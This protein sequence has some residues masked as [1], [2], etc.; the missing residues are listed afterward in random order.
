MGLKWRLRYAI[1]CIFFLNHHTV[2]CGLLAYFF[3]YNPDCGLSILQYSN[4]N[5][6]GIL[7]STTLD[8]Q[9]ICANWVDEDMSDSI[10]EKMYNHVHAVLGEYYEADLRVLF[11]A[12]RKTANTECARDIFIRILHKDFVD[13]TLWNSAVYQFKRLDIL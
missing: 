12:V 9:F 5:L 2:D 8:S 4:I 10:L 1:S 7:R 3:T 11:T 13:F 6:N